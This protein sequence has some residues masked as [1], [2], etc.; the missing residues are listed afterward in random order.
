MFSPPPAAPEHPP[1]RT[2]GA[3]SNTEGRFATHTAT[4]E[5]DGW[6]RED[7]P[8]PPRPTE[9]LIDRTR[10]IITY[11]DAPDIPF[12]RSINPY[13][14]CEHGCIYCFARPSH[15]Y[16]D[17]SPG[18]D[19]ETKI[20]WKPDALKLLQQEL[21]KPGYKVA[22]I[23]FGTN[24]DPWQ[25]VERE[26]RVTRQLLE[27]LYECRHPVTVLTKGSL[28]L[29]DVDL[30]A[31]FAEQNLVHAMVSVTTL[32]NELKAKLEPRASSGTT[33]LRAIRQLAAAG[34]PVGVMAAPMIPFINDHEL[35]AILGSAREA[36]ATRAGY[37]LL[38][39][40]Y[41]VKDLFGEWL[42]THFPD[43]AERVMSAVR[44][45]HGSRDAKFLNRREHTGA[46]AMLMAQ[47]FAVARRKA[48]Y[49]QAVR[50]HDRRP[51]DVTRFCP[52]RPPSPQGDLFA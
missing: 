39:L 22:P 21:A 18:L 25:P 5:D 45:I 31:K 1:D 44:D 36:G 2:R 29:R 40:P 23:A 37:T 12:D 26:L 7:L 46:F 30:L 20:A 13:K 47:R 19:F 52:P 16:L 49:G 15:S 35:E 42:Q 14:G 10:R 41:E 48:G 33:R 38:R 6:F 24:T 50:G 28:I 32:D 27:F 3:V 9:L 34:V 8:P 51:L 11:N 4:G 17:L 43:R